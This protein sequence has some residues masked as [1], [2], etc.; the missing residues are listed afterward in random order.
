MDLTEKNSHKQYTQY[1][2]GKHNIFY[3]HE[4]LEL[5]VHIVRILFSFYCQYNHAFQITTGRYKTNS[6]WPVLNRKSV[7]EILS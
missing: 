7:L 6:V 3:K 4:H 2:Y 1:K 5:A